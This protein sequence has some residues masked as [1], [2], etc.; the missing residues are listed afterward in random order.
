MHIRLIAACL[1]PALVAP[2]LAQERPIAV[3]GARVLPIAGEPIDDGVLVVEGGKIVAVGPRASVRLPANV[4][5]LD[6]QGKVVMPGLVDTHS[7]VG[8]GWGADSS[9]SIQPSVRMLDA[10]NCRDSGLQR[11][12]A[13][14]ITTLN[15]MSGSGHLM[16]GQTIYL[17]NRDADTVEELAYRFADG[18]PMGGM[19]MANGTNSHEPPPFPGTRGKS[20]ALVREHFVAAQEYARKVQATGNDPTKLPPR[21]LAME[22]L[23]DILSKKRIVHHHT[24]RHDDIVTVLRLAKEF[25][26]RVVLHHVSEAWKVAD[27]IVAAQAPC[28]LI[29]IDAPGGKLEAAQFDA[30]SAADLEQRGAPHLVAFHTDDWITDSRLFLRSAAL[31]V[32]A[33]CSR[34]TALAGLTK[35]PAAMLDLADRVGT[36][37][38]GKDAD[39]LVLSGDPLSVYTKVQETWVEGRK[40]FDITNE[41]DRKYADGGWGVGHPRVETL[42]CLAGGDR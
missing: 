5:V 25:D 1:L 36:L 34:E 21:D 10:V 28:S 8:G 2:A 9:A 40:V 7:H 30:R 16:S 33:G 29:V 18:T 31:A 15:V 4:L 3:V 35:N 13:G 32:R 20:A 19:K 37:E 27:E 26:F 14:G 42:C 38:P 41:A 11:A 24:H 12:Q 39:F 6:A 23:L 17:K 22:G